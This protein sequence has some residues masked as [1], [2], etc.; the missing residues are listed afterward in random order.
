MDSFIKPTK[1]LRRDGDVANWLQ[2]HKKFKYYHEAI[3]GAI[4]LNK[5]DAYFLPRCNLTYGRH[6]Y[7]TCSQ[8]KGQTFDTYLA[9]LRKKSETCEF[10]AL[11]DDLI[12][13]RIV[14]GIRDNTLSQ[15]LLREHN[16]TLIQ[17]INTCRSVE[18]TDKWLEMFQ[19]EVV[20]HSNVRI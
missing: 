7:F 1:K 5:V 18:V 13:D 4:V 16:L 17:A 14:C 8:R 3:G 9:E 2:W 19:A 12:K 20:T 11:G 15:Q 6:V 10:G